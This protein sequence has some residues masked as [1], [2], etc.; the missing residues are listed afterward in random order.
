MQKRLFAAAKKVQ[1]PA[2]TIRQG[3]N[4]IKNSAKS[5]EHFDPRLLHWD[6]SSKHFLISK[7]KIAGIIDWEN[8]KGSDPIQEFARWHFYNGDEELQWLMEGYKNKGLFKGKFYERLYLWKIFFG[9]DVLE[10]YSR[11][12]N[13]S[14]I[15]HAK[16]QLQEDLNYF[17][18]YF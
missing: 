16:Q 3:L 12:Q 15:K 14:G 8:C 18:K 7:R 1:L 17:K 4:I 2:S 11:E 10:Y 5:Y 6:Y 13:Q 9:M